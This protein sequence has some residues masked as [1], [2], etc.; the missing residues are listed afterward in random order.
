MN[1]NP[2]IAGETDDQRDIRENKDIA[3]FSYVWIMALAI[4]FA[5][6]D[7]KFIRYHSKQGLILFVVSI[8]LAM[9]PVFGRLLLFIPVAGMLLGFVHA[10]QGTYADVPIVGGL[11]KGELSITDALKQVGAFLK[12]LLDGF[13]NMVHKATP[14]KE[15][16][17]P[18]PQSAQS[19]VDNLP[20]PQVP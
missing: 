17:K 19:T 6:R 13:M 8:L 10:A 7:S 4:Y 20:P 1:A 5:R 18:D 12:S 3:A 16:K 2:P 9:I 14:K 15:E 11:A